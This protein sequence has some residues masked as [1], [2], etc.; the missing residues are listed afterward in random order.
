[1][2]NGDHGAVTCEYCVGVKPIRQL[3]E[4]FVSERIA[5]TVAGVVIKEDDLRSLEVM[6]RPSVG[7]KAIENLGSNS[8]LLKADFGVIGYVVIHGLP[9]FCG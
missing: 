7:Q 4:L 3:P 9:S 8:A 2:A 1:M 6:L 5:Y